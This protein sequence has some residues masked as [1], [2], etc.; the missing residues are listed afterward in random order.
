MPL[1]DKQIKTE[2]DFRR[3][4]MR[5]DTEDLLSHTEDMIAAAS[6][7][8]ERYARSRQKLAARF[9]GA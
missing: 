8:H 1:S 7:R 3:A 2:T 4:S 6:A 5:F 9:A